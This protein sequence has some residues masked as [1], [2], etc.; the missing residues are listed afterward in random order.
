MHSIGA[1]V[2]PPTTSILPSE[3]TKCDAAWMERTAGTDGSVD[4]R[5]ERMGAGYVVGTDLVPLMT[6]LIRVGGSTG[7]DQSRSCQSVP[8]SVGCSSVFWPP[9]SPA[10]VCRLSSGPG[11]LEIL[12]KWGKHDYHPRLREIVH[13]DVICP[14]LIELQQ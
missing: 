12:H 9:H 13:F 14:L 5:A 2:Q 10:C 11:L 4:L 7:Y 8:A 6:L 3:T 1:R